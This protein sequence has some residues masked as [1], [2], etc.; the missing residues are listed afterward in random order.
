MV[1]RIFARTTPAARLVGT[2]PFRSRR[3]GLSSVSSTTFL[4]TAQSGLSYKET[5]STRRKLENYVSP[6]PTSRAAVRLTLR[7]ESWHTSSYS[8]HINV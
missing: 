7:V 4:V 8:C 5:R 2:V 6:V 3:V 1:A